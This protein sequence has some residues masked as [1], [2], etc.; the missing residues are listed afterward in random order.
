M[1]DPFDITVRE[2]LNDGFNDGVYNPGETTEDTKVQAS[3]SL[4]AVQVSPGRAYLRGYP[5]QSTN[6]K[7]LDVPKPRDFVSLQNNIVPFELGNYV[8]VNNV[9]GSPLITG[10]NITPSY[11]ILELKDRENLTPG[12]SNGTTI[13]FARVSNWELEDTSDGVTGNSNDVYKAF[14]F[15]VALFTKLKLAASATIIAGSQIVGKSSGATGYIRISGGGTSVTSDDLELVNVT[16]N[17]REGEVISVDGRDVGSISKIYNYQFSDVR[18]FI[19]RDSSNAV[20]FSCNVMFSDSFQLS[21]TRYTYNSSTNVLVGFNSNISLEVR[22]YDRLYFAPGNY[23]LVGGV[24]A[25]YDLST[26]FNYQDQS[27]SVSLRTDSGF[28]TVTPTNGQQFTS[29]F[30]FRPKIEDT[31]LDDLFIE[32][33]KELHPKYQ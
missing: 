1:I 32:L 25:G 31:Q 13:G 23:F 12:S 14:L 17:F 9:Y 30:R 7:Y 29:I 33:P 16:G 27:I 8:L 26:V 6:P 15:D 3:E 19:G 22:P 10:P 18:Q 4:Y 28:S 11:Q 5:I 24:P 2:C 20:A 21:G